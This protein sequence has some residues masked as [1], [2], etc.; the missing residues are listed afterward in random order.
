MKKWSLLVMLLLCFA[1]PFFYAEAS[2]APQR[3]ATE[4]DDVFEPY[5]ADEWIVSPDEEPTDDQEVD[6]A[7]ECDIYGVIACYDADYLR[8]D[9]LLNNEISFDLDTFYCVKFEYDSMNEYYTYYVDTEELVYE[10]E[11]NGKITERKTLTK[12][13]SEDVAGISDSND[14]DNADIYFII[15]K[16]DHIGGT[17]G[18]RYYLTSTFYSGFIDSKNKLN[19]ADDTI[20][21]D[22]E[23]E[24]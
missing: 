9:I 14:L 23:F 6:N 13:N 1:L 24:Y 4:V 18:K 17:E 8:V 15:N 10:K 22:M 3:N 16:E 19:I 11:K 5:T 12:K 20:D 21:V 2:G 7:P